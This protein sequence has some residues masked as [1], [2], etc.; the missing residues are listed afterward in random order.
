MSTR[1]ERKCPLCEKKD[2]KYLSAHLKNK[3][4]ILD[5]KERASFLKRSLNHAE[6]NEVKR[7]DTVLSGNECGLDDFNEQERILCASFQ[8]M[9]DRILKLRLHAMLYYAMKLVNNASD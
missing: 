7:E 3:H 9:K 4:K 8:D 2:I 6:E 5:V 1:K